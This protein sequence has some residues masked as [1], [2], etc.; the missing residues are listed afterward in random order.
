[1]NLFALALL[2]SSDSAPG[3][4]MAVGLMIFWLAVVVLIVAS[5][6]KLFEKAG[7]PGWAAIVPIYNFMILLKIAGKPMWWIVL[8]FIPFV[9]FIVAIIAGIAIARNFGKGTGFGLGLAF[10][11]PIFYPIL[12]FGDA[13]YQ[14][15]AQ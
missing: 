13:R 10:L 7:E 15:V 8:M 5:M 6:W 2:Q 11:G 9:N 1:V 12:A 4:G 3:A 14:P